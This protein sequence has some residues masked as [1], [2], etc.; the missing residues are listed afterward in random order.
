MAYADEYIVQTE[1]LVGIANQIRTELNKNITDE[2]KKLTQDNCPITL[3]DMVS[4]E[5]KVEGEERV[6][7]KIE[8]VFNSG[9]QSE[10]DSFWDMYQNGGKP[11]NYHWAFAYNRFSNETY[12]PKHPIRCVT[13]DISTL[14]AQSIFRDNQNITD[15][16][17]EI[18]SN[19]NSM[20][21]CFN[22]C[23]ALQTIRKIHITEAVD[24][25]YA[26]QAC[27]ALKN[28]EFEGTIGKTIEFTQ[29]KVLSAESVQNIIDNLMP[30]TDGEARTLKLH[31]DVRKNLTTLQEVIITNIHPDTGEPLEDGVGWTDPVT[32]ER[33]E[34]GKGWTLSPT[35]T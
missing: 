9:K 14:G 6:V 16:K 21:Y 5:P 28:I 34:K 31:P 25:K 35:R 20:S 23:Y 10:K 32:G 13:S 22:Q 8:Q 7:G 26:F 33:V 2:E 11:Q 4:K 30:I 15:T 24:F 17:V 29:S 19:G 27:V 18:F 12:D 1:E 3:E